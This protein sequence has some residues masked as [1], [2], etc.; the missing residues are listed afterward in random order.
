MN[1]GGYRLRRSLRSGCTGDWIR[2]VTRYLILSYRVTGG[3]WRKIE[4]GDVLAEHLVELRG[5]PP[6]SGRRGAYASS[7][8]F[9]GNHAAAAPLGMVRC[10]WGRPGITLA[11]LASG[12]DTRCVLRPE[13]SFRYPY[14]SLSPSARFAIHSIYHAGVGASFR[15]APLR[16]VL[17][18]TG[19]VS[20]HWPH[21]SRHHRTCRRFR[22]RALRRR[23]FPSRPV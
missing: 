7:G 8:E 19:V 20:H 13:R 6:V 9:C 2:R 10:H 21:Q 12:V 22:R 11:A 4:L 17:K 15:L 23:G 18:H 3:R 16:R 1:F 5:P 14:H